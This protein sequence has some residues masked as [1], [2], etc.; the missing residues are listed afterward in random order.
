MIGGLSFSLAFLA[1]PLVNYCVKILGSKPTLFIG[2]LF[3]SGAFIG[4]SFATEIW[5]LFLSQGVALGIGIGFMFD[6]TAGIIPQWFTKGRAFANGLGS[7][8]T[9]TGGMIYSLATFAMVPRLG[10]AWTFRT[11]AIIQFVVCGVC[12]L[13]LKDRNKQ[14]GSSLA[15]FDI[16]LLKRPE[17]ILLLG[18]SFFSM[19]GYVTLLFSLPNWAT[20]I[21]LTASQGSIVGAMACLGQSVSR[22]IVGHFADRSGCLSIATAGTVLAGFFCFVFWIFVQDFAQAVAFALMSGAVTG[23]YFT[24]I[25]PVCARVVGLVELPAGL[26]V[27]W[28]GIVLPSL[29]AEPIALEMHRTTGKI[30]LDIQ[31]FSGCMFFAAAVCLFFVRA[32]KIKEIIRIARED[33]KL[34]EKEE[35]IDPASLITSAHKLTSQSKPVPKWVV[36]GKHVAKFCEWEKV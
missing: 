27:V 30:Y 32:W 1:A 28:I 24:L 11:L 34:D 14:I 4:A 6:A 20:T 13:L 2:V 29:F 35:Q 5:H 7:A 26:S 8:G 22:P 19:L 25:A 9:G 12:A 23:T 33:G 31:I 18:W 21:G 36:Y 16:K 15:S 10:L 3:Q 17:F